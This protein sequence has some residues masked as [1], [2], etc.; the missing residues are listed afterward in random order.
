MKINNKGFVLAETLVVTVFVMLIF[1]IIY[2]NFY[3]ILGKYQE[4]EYFDDIDSKY[5]TYWLKRFFQDENIINDENWAIIK[6][7]IKKNGGYEF[8]CKKS[9]NNGIV[10][11]NCPLVSDDKSIKL[12]MGFIGTTNCQHI[13]ITKYNLEKTAHMTNEEEQ[14]T[15]VQFKGNTPNTYLKK[16]NTQDQVDA[17]NSEYANKPMGDLHIP[18]EDPLQHFTVIDNI[19]STTKRYI[20]YLPAYKFPS[21]RGA[22]YRIIAEYAKVD[23][24]SRDKA[25]VKKIHTFATIELKRD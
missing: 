18:P 4:R 19:N 1:T 25:D 16:F 11:N 9:N 12:I 3:P 14:D 5:D 2:A 24:D 23:D 8:Y 21:I 13:F 6:E 15:T 7:H 17:F 20:E 22:N 10:S